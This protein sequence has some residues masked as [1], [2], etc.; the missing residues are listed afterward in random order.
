MSQG[1]SIQ[2]CRLG[3]LAYLEAWT[4]QKKL[5]ELRKRNLIEDCLLILEHPHVI[6]YGRNVGAGSLLLNESDLKTRGVELVESDRGGDAT[7]HGPGQLI[8]YPIIDL[9]VDMQDIRKYVWTLEEC[10][11]AVMAEYGITGDRLEGAPGAWLKAQTSDGQD[12]KMGA[13][14]IRLSRWVTHHGIGFNV[15]TDL[16]FF[17]LIV[18]CGLSDKGVTSLESVKGRILDFRQVQDHFIKH[19]SRL[20]NR[21][22]I[23]LSSA[24]LN[25]LI[26]DAKF[27]AE[28]H[29]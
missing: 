7:Y 13:V 22:V 20:F 16:S 6:T 12:C 14:G 24:K 27:S 1:P 9:K 25:I 11:I 17:K 15:N 4:L 19:F 18:P 3:S 21:E 26:Q 23:E 29:S 28:E 10:M 5:A 8:A 2:V